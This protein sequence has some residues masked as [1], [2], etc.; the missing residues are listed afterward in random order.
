MYHTVYI[1]I[2]LSSQFMSCLIPVRKGL[3]NDIGVHSR[4]LEHVY[5]W[6]ETVKGENLTVENYDEVMSEAGPAASR[7]QEALAGVRGQLQAR[8]A[9]ARKQETE[10]R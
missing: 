3:A 6:Q 8:A 5:Q 9:R 10:G 1:N 4:D 7:I 2:Y